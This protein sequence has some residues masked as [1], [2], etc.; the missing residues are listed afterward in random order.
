MTDATVETLAPEGAG[1]VEMTEDDA[2]SAAYDSAQVE[3]PDPEP[4]TESGA[5]GG[6]PGTEP[7]VEAGPAPDVPS[8]IP[9]ELKA[10]WG[11]LPENARDSLLRSHRSMAE[12]VSEASRHKQAL[13]PILQAAQKVAREIPSFK[14]MRPAEVA[15][16]VFRLAQIQHRMNT[17]PAT[18]LRE[19]AKMYQ[20]DVGAA[21]AANNES[22][23]MVNALRTQIAHLEQRLAATPQ[24]VNQMIAHNAMLGRVSEFAKGQEH[25]PDVEA[26]LPLTIPVA[27]AKMGQNAEPLAV[28]EMAYQMAIDQFVPTA[29]AKA[30]AG[31]EPAPAANPERAKAVI[32]AKSVNVPEKPPGA[33]AQLTEDEALAAVYDRV[34]AN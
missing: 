26:K 9:G 23:Q 30:R 16:R 13:G 14:D 4:A 5:E 20:V 10:I 7:D 29:R 19:L 11:D 22:A 6:E 12:K 21:G 2:L 32:R 15:D 28:L 24:Q 31:D 3:P 17:D 27:Q 1:S 18:T 34:N 8:D 25:W 33:K